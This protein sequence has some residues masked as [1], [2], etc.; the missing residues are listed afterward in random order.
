MSIDGFG[1]IHTDGAPSQYKTHLNR[2]MDLSMSYREFSQKVFLINL[3]FFEVCNSTFTK[4]V[5]VLRNLMNPLIPTVIVV[6]AL[7]YNNCD[8]CAL[9][10]NSFKLGQKLEKDCN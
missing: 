4:F 2:N 7:P 3:D 1:R 8:H 6:F 5:L 9:P 10:S